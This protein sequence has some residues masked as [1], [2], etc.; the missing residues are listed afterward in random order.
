MCTSTP[1]LEWPLLDDRDDTVDY[2]RTPWFPPD[3]DDRMPWVSLPERPVN[4]DWAYPVETDHAG[5]LEDDHELQD[6]DN[7][8]EEGIA[9]ENP[10]VPPPKAKKPARKV[11]PAPQGQRPHDPSNYTVVVNG[12]TRGPD[13]GIGRAAAEFARHRASYDHVPKGRYVEYDLC[14]ILGIPFKR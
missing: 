10:I 3:F 4:P 13:W 2:D 9:C 14:E 1:A 7:F 6:L 12:E 8:P 5:P 11:T